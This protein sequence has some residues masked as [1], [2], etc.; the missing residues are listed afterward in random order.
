VASVGLSYDASS[1]D[2][3]EGLEAVR[4][5]PG[6][7][8][9]DTGP[10]GFH[11]LL[12]EIL[13]NSVDEALAGFASRVEVTLHA[14]GSASVRDDGRGI[15]VDL[16]PLL[17]RPG[18]E[19][20]M[21]VLHAGGK[22]SGK[23]YKVSGGLHGVGASVVN[24]LS[25]WTEVE[26][27]RDGYLW[28]QTF[29]RG[30]P[31]SELVKVG[32]AQGSGTTVRFKPDREIFG[33]RSFSADAVRGRLRE[34]SFL[35][36]G[37]VLVFRD[38]RGDEPFEEV[39][40]QRGGLAD[41]VDLLCEGSER[42]FD[43]PLVV[44]GERDG[45]SVEVALL[46]EDSDIERL[47]S[48]ANLIP[49]RDGGTHVSGFRS[50]LT[51]AV[52]EVCSRR[53]LLNGKKFDSISGDD[54]REGLVAVLSVKLPDPQ[55]EGQTK[56]KL[57]NVEV[58]GAVESVVYEGLCSLFEEREEAL[59]A[60]VE[61][62]IKTREIREA[63][64]RARELVSRKGTLSSL[65][66]PCKLADCSSRDPRECELFIV[67]GDSA[68]GS[69]K[70]ARDRHFQAILPLRGKILNVEKANLHKALSNAE[71][72]AI[73][74]SLG[75]GFGTKVDLSRLRYHKVILMTD[76][77]VDGAHIRTLLLTFFFRYIRELI[78]GGHLYIAQPPLYLVRHRKGEVYCYSE[79]E[80]RRVTSGLDGYT[81]QRYK[82][83]GEMNPRQLWETTMDPRRRVL[84]QVEL[85]DAAA[86]EELLSLLM[87]GKVEPRRRFIERH[88]REV[89]N[90]DV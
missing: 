35:V 5:R 34:L 58:K 86:A 82:G 22:F 85:E 64:R 55:F 13:D 37:L 76:A 66:L 87:G 12:Y 52:N 90:L 83:L 89:R 31:T 19:V 15:P 75:C 50:A 39:F 77:D 57:G 68:G 71:I 53:K 46:Y 59:K 70:Q 72:K 79:E 1:I 24:A 6:M 73:I 21:T 54:L 44:S 2:V 8:I 84:Y 23:V 74:Q 30:N 47:Y 28:R 61:K 51:R 14:D 29:S 18:V 62:A 63:E 16:H 4:R 17:G 42:L 25:E 10:R 41:F 3:L 56:G 43:E 88:V 11:H 32:P 49:T 78:E 80:L 40:L 65:D 60:I 20:V 45:V 38:D 69:A 48:F 81:V 26:V 36:P 27:T 67:E 7:Y 9:G 33:D